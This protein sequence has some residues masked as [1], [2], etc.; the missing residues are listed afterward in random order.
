MH[1]LGILALALLTWQTQPSSIEGIVLRGGTTQP[2]WN[3]VV[4]LR[5]EGKSVPIAVSTGADGKFEFWNVAPGRYRLAVSRNGYLDSAYGQRGPNG[6]GSSLSVEAGQTLKNIRITMVATGAISGR[7]RD[8]NGEPLANVA[9]QAMKYSYLDGERKLESVKTDTT[10]DRGEYRLFWLPPGTYYVTAQP[11]GQARVDSV[12]VVMSGDASHRAVR[13]GANGVILNG[14]SSQI[15]KLGQAD[16]PLFYPGTVDSQAAVPVDLRPGSDIGGIDFGLERVKTRVVRG[17]LIDG[18]TGQPTT[19]ANVALVPRQPSV[20]GSQR[21]V[22]SSDG[23]FEIQGVLP[24]SYYLY[25]STRTNASGSA[26]R[27]TGGRIPVDVAGGDVD[28]LA[29]VLSPALEIQGDLT[30]DGPTPTEDDNLHPVI[31]LKNKFTGI[32]AIAQIYGSFKNNRQFTLDDVV[33]GDYRVQIEYLPKGTYV[34]SIRFGST[35]ALN[36]TISIDRRSSDRMEVVVSS[37]GGKINGTVLNKN[38]EPLSNT[39]VALV[40]EASRRER[41]DLYRSAMTDESGSFHLEAI[42]P[43]EYSL[44]AWEDIEDNLWRDPEFIRRNEALGKRISI[45]EATA[46]NIEITANPFEF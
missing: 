3:A 16:A 18:L 17:T 40:P 36:G 32:P 2:I 46:E 5:G 35:D 30:I 24:G 6:S 38:R 14:N 31:T 37:N 29:I 42:A 8:S 28:R 23:G 7:V 22:P 1:F 44:F 19:S 41:A 12:F 45:R 21:G 15:E 43:G 34:K 13:F 33:E 26:Q 4:E 20:T 25:A 10:D 9:V 39:P 11:G 27:I